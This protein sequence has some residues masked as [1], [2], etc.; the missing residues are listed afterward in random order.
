[1]NIIKNL[2]VRTKFFILIML[3]AFGIVIVGVM[4]Y[5]Y[6]N[7]ADQNLKELYLENLKPI[8]L[9]S[10][11]RTQSTANKG[12][13]LELML[14]TDQSIRK[15]VLEDIQKRKNTIDD[16]LAAYE[17][18]E[19]DA[20]DIEQLSLIK[21]NITAWREVLNKTIELTDSGK[22]SEAYSLYV[23]TGSKALEDVQVS[24]SELTDY[25]IKVADQ[26]YSQN[27][28]DNSKAVRNL[29]TVIILVI[30][31]CM[32]LGV[33]ITLSI[34][35][36]LGRVVALI[37]ETSNFNLVYDNSFTYLLTHKDEV[38]IIANS[39]VTMRNELREMVG[40]LMTVS[41][42]LE[43]HSEELTASTK[44]YSR[45]VEQVATSINEI[46]D[47]NGSQ[48]EMISGTN[49]KI[50]EIVKTISEAN[51]ITALNAE[52]AGKSLDTIGYGQEAV[53][54]AA[55]RM[56]ENVI[57]SNDVGN[58]IN[59]LNQSIQKV[60]SFIQTINNIAEQ[61]NL[62][63]LNAAIEAARAGEAGKGFAVV[64]EEIRTLAEGSAS[65][66]KEITQIIRTTIDES[67]IA[68]KNVDRA[69]E[70]VE[71]Q[72]KAFGNTKQAFDK[73]KVSVEEIHQKVQ[74]TANM[75]NSIDTASKGIA[76]QT[77][78]MA[79]V[80]QQSAAGS[81]EIAATTEEQFSAIETIAKSASELSVMAV[82]LSKEISKF[83]L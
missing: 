77:H 52:N 19:L 14:T 4:G 49:A 7:L 32:L 9:L 23:E 12:N 50:A 55:E 66:A 17:K 16:N 61:T 75:L 83:Q 30:V 40:K 11:T 78:D 13:I 70:V 10:D 33:F 25:N 35:R 60:N 64:S 76:N 8:E 46:A 36:P 71:N 44:E 59:Q 1:M 18:T 24:I 41:E 74:D 72:S 54:F 5:Y 22:S 68:I 67:D 20:Y 56:N 21:K 37:N 58:S 69:R 2:K 6:K 53:D 31:I 48:A 39:V 57:I 28:Q 62:L 29:L 47:G 80:S 51:R 26:I 79:A 27:E 15:S 38:G 81:E 73:I 34:T 45:I 63:A 42:N 65:A 43:S 3:M 82:D